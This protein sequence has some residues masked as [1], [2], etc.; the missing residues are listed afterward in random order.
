MKP[1]W[2]MLYAAGADVV[3]NGHRHNYE[4]FALQD[5]NGAAD[6]GRGIR[7]II[8]GT[9]GEGLGGVNNVAPNSEVRNKTTWGVLKMTLHATSYDWEFVPVA[10]QTFTD[11]GS[12]PCVSVGGG[13]PTP[14]PTPS[15]T[16][17]P[18]LTPTPSSTPT[19]TPTPDGADPIFSDGFESGD[20]SAWTSNSNGSGDLSAS[21]GAALVGGFGL[22]ALINDNTSMYVTDDTPNAE[23]VY[24]SR[25]YFD[26]NSIS[27]VSGDTHFIFIGYSGTST[28]VLRLTFRSSK[29]AYQIR[30]NLL[31][32]S[33]TWVNTS[34]FTISDA[35]HY[36]ETYWRSD[37]TNGGLTLWV[38]GV[39]KA[40]LTGVANDTR[41][42]DRVRLGAV[43]GI[44]SGTRGTYYFDAFESR[45]QTYIGP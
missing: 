38:D 13:N 4:R 2:T 16:P 31:N 5:P 28:A 22:N 21:A 33:G 6:P 8:V 37:A 34:W 30:G 10:G 12:A 35:P 3:L 25:F 40:D 23:P 9:G 24:R 29:G 42:I 19:P 41:R 32:N 11:S 43:T 14:T 26:P 18:T 1:L 20:L 27:M 44:D 45:R 7:E 36:I 39:Q 17:T 15:N